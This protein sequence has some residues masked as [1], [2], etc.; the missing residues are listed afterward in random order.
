MAY[1]TTILLNRNPAQYQLKLG[2]TQNP[3]NT[4]LSTDLRYHLA[5]MIENNQLEL[6]PSS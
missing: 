6:F 1:A 3:Q 5:N 4:D 2:T